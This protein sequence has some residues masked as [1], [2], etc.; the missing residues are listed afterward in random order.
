MAVAQAVLR[1][2]DSEDGERAS[3]GGELP[4]RV[5]VSGTIPDGRS[6]GGVNRTL[7]AG[8][9]LAA[10]TLA[11]CGGGDETGGGPLQFS[12][13]LKPE[14]DA[15]A[16]RFL[17]HAGIAASEA[18][19]A[20]VKDQGY[21]PWL[22]R[23][24]NDPVAQ[25]AAGW[26]TEQGYDKVTEG[27]YFEQHSPGDNAMW[28]QL[29]TPDNPVRKRATLALSEF[30]VVGFG[31]I[32][33]NWRSQAIA[34]YW[35]VLSENAF[36]SYRTLLEEVTLHPAMGRFLNTRGNRKADPRSGR[37]PDENY[38]REVM[39]LFSIGLHE[40]NMDG[41]RKTDADGNPI[42]TYDND[43]VVGLA[44]VF[45][46]F[47]EDFGD[48]KFTRRIDRPDR[49]IA[50]PIV[51]KRRMTADHAR[52]ER[53]GKNSEHSEDQKNFLGVSIPAGTGPEESLRIALDTLADHPNT[54]PFFSRQMIQRL[55]TS[56]PS[57]AYVQRVA[58]TFADNGNGERGDLGA[59][60]KAI[61]LDEEALSDQT[62]SS[63]TFGKMREPMLRLA[64]WAQTFN[65]RSESGKYDVRDLSDPTRLGQSPM[66]APSVFNFFRPGFVP[67]NSN[68][69]AN[70][71]AAPEFALLDESSIA[72]NI[73]FM[74]SVV[75]GKQSHTKDLVTSYSDEVPLAHDP[76]ALLDRLDLLLTGQQLSEASRN[77]IRTA[78]EARGVTETSPQED[79]LRQ[80]QTA[81]ML[82][83]AA[84]EYVIQR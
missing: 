65:A 81:V 52:W 28:H 51:A 38:A 8:A 15:A 30:F 48:V 36:G 79:K 9:S 75:E 1:S 41:S 43:D 58:E 66:R 20:A 77:T 2:F 74:M 61:L 19:I 3:E 37:E 11:A 22:N 34:H 26:L 49:E 21:E 32:S 59:V 24:L 82:V 60:F 63:L 5:P 46:G 55:V 70:D 57:P 53:P 69:S 67:P 62:A 6:N 31:S 39:Q 50:D 80:V 7:A 47:N 45:T 33:M 76:S 54:A 12:K 25:T 72:A 10:L 16:A 13:T 27:K 68:A 35:D 4:E 56:N 83:L 14:T 84:P 23:Q 44:H 29:L 71:L 18:D 40:L 73:N 64:Q 42:E 17:L 78:L